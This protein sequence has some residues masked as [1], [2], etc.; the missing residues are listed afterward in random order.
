MKQIKFTLPQC[1]LQ[2]RHR[3]YVLHTHMY[4][5]PMYYTPTCTHAHSEVMKVYWNPR[6][7]IR[8]AN[9]LLERRGRFDSPRSPRFQ[10]AMF[11]ACRLN[12]APSLGK[13]QPW[14]GELTT[15]L[16]ATGNSEVSSQGTHHSCE[17]EPNSSG[18]FCQL[19]FPSC[20][21]LKVQTGSS[22][23][24][25]IVCRI[26]TM[27]SSHQTKAIDPENGCEKTQ[28]VNEKEYCLEYSWGENYRVEAWPSSLG[29]RISQGWEG[30]GTD[31]TSGAL[32]YSGEVKQ[33][34]LLSC[35]PAATATQ[36]ITALVHAGRSPL[37]DTKENTRPSFAMPKSLLGN[38]TIEIRLCRSGHF[39]R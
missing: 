21:G 10:E 23:D 27:I 25:K 22:S 26:K 31:S 36:G 9:G 13:S 6:W 34:T 24:I 8:H 28:Q 5:E 33:L 38:V 19:L 20:L 4:T 32:V 3:A 14:L 17:L 39:L 37:H 30:Q 2:I 15:K 35:F 12:N 16:P 11:K 7:L 29:T 18:F 1:F